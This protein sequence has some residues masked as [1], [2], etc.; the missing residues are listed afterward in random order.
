MIEIE[1]AVRVLNEL[2]EADPEATNKFFH[3]GVEVNKQVCDHP[4]I[5]VRTDRTRMDSAQVGDDGILRPL[6][7]LNGLLQGNRVIVMMMDDS[8]TKITGFAVGI[9]EDGKVRVLPKNG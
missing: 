4:T 7:L 8:E 6:G 2:L 5:Q 9:L 1:N 3:L